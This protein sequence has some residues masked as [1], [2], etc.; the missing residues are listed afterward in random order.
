MEDVVG[1][2]IWRSRWEVVGGGGREMEGDREGGALPIVYW[3]P[4]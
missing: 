2:G 3:W 1:V 4:R